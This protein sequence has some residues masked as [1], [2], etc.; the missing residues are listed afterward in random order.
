M[1]LRKT[2]AAP[3]FTDLPIGLPVLAT[4]ADNDDLTYSVDL[5]VD[6]RV[7]NSDD[8]MGQLY[9]MAGQRP[10]FSHEN[11]PDPFDL[12]VTV[13]DGTNSDTITVTITITDVDE[14]PPAPDPPTV[15][16]AASDGHSSL[17]V[18]WTD[19]GIF[20]AGETTDIP[21][22]DYYDLRYRISGSVDES[23]KW[24]TRTRSPRPAPP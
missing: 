7:G 8:D 9:L 6:W 21:D 10:N 20:I 17:A 18:S 3:P 11:L 24:N 16:A 15:E 14:P 4:D 5:S 2:E 13:S 22:T 23:R 1:P 12:I 19:P